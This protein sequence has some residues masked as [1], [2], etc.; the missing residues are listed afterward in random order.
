M[1]Y[2]TYFHTRNDTGAVFYVGQGSGRRAHDTKHDDSWKRIVAEHGRTVHLAMT[3]LTRDEAHEHERFLIECFRGMGAP[4]LNKEPGGSGKGYKHSAEHIANNAKAKIGKKHGPMSDVQK[5][6]LRVVKTGKKMSDTARVNMAA[7]QNN[8]ITKAKK[9][10]AL[11]GK[12]TG[13]QNAR[14]MRSEAAKSAMRASWDKRKS[15]AAL[16]KK[17]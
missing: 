4:L 5:E 11:K 16:N 10:S 9:S 13:N 1:N 2:Y 12:N 6:K 15:E 8:P 14:G 17:E 7:A 3:R